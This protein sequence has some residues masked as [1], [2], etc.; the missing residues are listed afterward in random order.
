MSL[1]HEKQKHCFCT[2]S[3]ISLG[4]RLSE[5]GKATHINIYLI[6]FHRRIDVHE[7]VCV[8]GDVQ[9]V[10]GDTLTW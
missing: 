5:I 7:C 4:I 3:F 10:R 8:H 9:P 6:S 2:P 1:M